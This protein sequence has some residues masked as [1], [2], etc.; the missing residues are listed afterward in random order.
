MDINK[1]T[2]QS[3]RCGRKVGEM[4]KLVKVTLNNYYGFRSIA[5]LKKIY[6]TGYIILNWGYQSLNRE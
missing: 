6:Q 2:S 1:Q 3:A 5:N 4:N